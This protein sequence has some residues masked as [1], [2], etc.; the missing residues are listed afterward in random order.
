MLF[1]LTE[2]VDLGD[3]FD[4]V[5][6]WGEGPVTGG[7]GEEEV[8]ENGEAVEEGMLGC[9][10]RRTNVSVLEVSKGGSGERM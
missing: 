6:E 5:V 4:D 3:D 7:D 2:V 1:E 9:R 8:V 10:Y